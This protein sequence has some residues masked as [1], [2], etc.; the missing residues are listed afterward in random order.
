VKS[1]ISL[2][3]AGVADMYCQAS[4]RLVLMATLD[5]NAQNPVA[6]VFSYRRMKKPAT[7]L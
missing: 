5:S 3:F 2:I 7:P 4:V 1:V 6:R